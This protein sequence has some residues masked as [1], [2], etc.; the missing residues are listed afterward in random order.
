MTSIKPPRLNTGDTV[1]LISV[2][3]PV[4]SQKHLDRM[5]ACIESFGLNAVTGKSAT[6]G[7]GSQP[8]PAA[9][10]LSDLN[11]AIRDE[12]SKGILCAWGGGQAEELLPD[13][14]YDAFLR[15]PKPF[16]GLS[17]PS[18]IVTALQSRTGVVTFHGPTGCDFADPAGLD[19]YSRESFVSALFH[20]EPVGVLPAHSKWEIKQQ[21]QATGRLIGGNLARTVNLAG[22]PYEPDWSGSILMWEVVTWN[23]HGIISE[24][25]KLKNAGVLD[26]I[27]GMIVA[28]PLDQSCPAEPRDWDEILSVCANHDFPIVANV[29]CGHA[30]PKLTL[31]IGATVELNLEDTSPTISVLEAGVA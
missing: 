14:D 23:I 7:D 18:Y 31:P 29:D 22:T 12:N 16:V 3:H 17:D 26:C 25:L 24:I 21:G 15:S 5:L 27:S 11:W 19:A 1:A 10:R 8:A 28:C 6:F 13:I 4:P 2:S 30:S 9:L 20:S